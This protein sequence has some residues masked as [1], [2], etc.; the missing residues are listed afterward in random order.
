MKNYFIRM[1]R[2][3]VSESGTEGFMQLFEVTPKQIK[4]V[5]TCDTLEPQ[6]PAFNAGTFILKFTLSPRFSHKAPYNMI[7]GCKV[8][9]ISG[10]LN[11]TEFEH[12]GIRIHCGNTHLDTDGCILVG[13][14]QGTCTFELTESRL[15]YCTLM[16]F[17]KDA[18]SEVLFIVEDNVLPF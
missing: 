12:R 8:P 16:E 9:I 18:Y 6:D 10:I 15:T 1:F 17:L 14:S 3:H 4:H 7:Q 11:S 2:T 5:Y 13:R